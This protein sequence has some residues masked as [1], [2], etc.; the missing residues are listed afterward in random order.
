MPRTLALRH[1]I[2]SRCQSSAQ[3]LY[4]R[5][6]CN[7]GEPGK[8]LCGDSDGL[9]GWWGEGGGE[10]EEGASNL[11]TVLPE[12]EWH[13]SLL[14]TLFF[15]RKRPTPLFKERMTKAINQ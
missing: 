14:F 9:N 1:N 11:S 13:V 12:S 15:R 8:R 6:Q 4:R 3:I 5:R 10:S 7:C 2:Q